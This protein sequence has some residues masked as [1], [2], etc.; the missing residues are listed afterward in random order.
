MRANSAWWWVLHFSRKET[1]RKH[2]GR[3]S[4]TIR[5]LICINP[6][7]RN[8]DSKARSTHIVLDENEFSLLCFGDIREEIILVASSTMISFNWDY[9]AGSRGQ[10]RHRASTGVVWVSR[11]IVSG[12]YMSL[13]YITGCRWRTLTCARNRNVVL[14]C[15]R[16]SFKPQSCVSFRDYLTALLDEFGGDFQ[17]GLGVAENG[18]Q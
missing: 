6:I 11:A 4:E 8:S 9:V 14:P 17:T 12:K 18:K 1:A 7:E 2:T 13:P 10:V 5:N 15:I 3:S 16:G